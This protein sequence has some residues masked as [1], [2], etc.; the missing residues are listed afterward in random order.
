MYQSTLTK[1]LRSNGSS[2]G[3]TGGTAPIDIGL[4][5]NIYSSDFSTNV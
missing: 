2:M 4:R 1:S 3:G 5:L